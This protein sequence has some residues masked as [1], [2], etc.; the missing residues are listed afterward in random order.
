[1][2]IGQSYLQKG[3]CMTKPNTNEAAKLPSAFSLFQPSLDGITRN[4]GTFL[5]IV[6]LPILA[7][8]FLIVPAL[9]SNI[10]S[11]IG[12]VFGGL[13]IFLSIPIIIAI[14]LVVP[15]SMTILALKSTKDKDADLED[16]VRSGFKFVWRYL[17]YN[18][19]FSLL[20]IGGFILFIVPG[21]IVLRR[22]LLAGYY[23]V[24]KDLGI[25]EA[26]DK[27]AAESKP[28]SGA[29]WGLIGVIF[30]INLLSVFGVFG[31]IVGFVL[32]IIYTF[33]PAVRYHQI[34]EA[35]KH[36]A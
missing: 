29:I 32:S 27:S 33:A 6:L 4:L 16:T 30:L 15:P 36:K 19:L 35:S 21:L 3:V 20:L 10:D 26:M 28:F 18:I 34:R 9:F 12:T 5:G 23:L 31:S 7:L 17:G 8:T 11:P 2:L 13:T 14:A 22:Y 25:R 24:D 1:M